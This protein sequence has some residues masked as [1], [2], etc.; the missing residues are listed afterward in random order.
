MTKSAESPATATAREGCVLVVSE[1]STDGVLIKALL[2]ED[3]DNVVTMNCPGANLAAGE[4]LELHPKVLL[5]A[6]RETDKAEQC[7]LGLYRS[8]GA[9]ALQ[10][11]RSVLLCTKESVKQAF[12]LCRRGLFDDYVLFWPMTYDAPRLR[13]TV[14]RALAELAASP[15][16]APSARTIA[17]Q[18]RRILE[19]EARL[20]DQLARG[21]EHIEAAGH[22]VVRAERDAAL[23][24]DGLSS[25]I[26]E[27]VMP[28]FQSVTES[29]H[30]LTQWAGEMQQTMSA[31][32]ES[33][34]TLG[35]LSTRVHPI[36]LIIENDEVEQQRLS[37]ILEPDGYHVKFASSGTEALRQLHRSPV[38][39]ILIEYKLP[40]LNGLEVAKR[41]KDD[42]R[43]AA[44]PVIMISANCDRD[45]VLG[46]RR[47]GAVDFIV[48]P[49]DRGVILDKLRRLC[50]GVEP[51][52]AHSQ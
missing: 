6:F 9:G 35:E 14:H 28:R 15:E 17:A 24:L 18:A 36:V 23:A 34:R 20:S 27:S 33:G 51:N 44:I 45:I 4:F 10:P 49:V 47:V 39:I 19:L 26:L 40:E 1:S 29:L 2:K 48:K 25:S 30:P 38:D 37:D 16:H 7:Y 22:A 52:V 46:S 50:A 12:E 21:Q 5:L 42:P 3:F 41:L 43:L 8:Q 31:H 13:M 32:R 11:H